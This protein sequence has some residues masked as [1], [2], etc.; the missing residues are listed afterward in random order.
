M[1]NSDEATLP[2]LAESAPA[3]PVRNADKDASA[4]RAGTFSRRFPGMLLFMQLMMI[5]C[6]VLVT[7]AFNLR[8][9]VANE[10]AREQAN[11]LAELSLA[12]TQQSNETLALRQV[13][14]RQSHQEILFLKVLALKPSVD[15]K[16]AAEIARHIATYANLYGY[17]PDLVLAI[18]YTESHFD[19]KAVSHKG[20]EGLMQIMPQWKKVL[21]VKGDLSDTE[22]SVKV[23]LQVFGFYRE[24]YPDVKLA[25]TAYNRGP[26]PV[27]HALMKGKDPANGY[28]A[29]VLGIY[30]R[31]KAMTIAQN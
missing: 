21:G 30:D 12:A 10:L 29:K 31:L 3:K 6:L 27:D 1:T 5:V 22:T 26:G 18:M 7:Y 11:R 24:M 17:D 20:A 8:L 14:A 25:L 19:K 23:G 28:S 9:N 2:R 15:T 4:E 13:V 16:V